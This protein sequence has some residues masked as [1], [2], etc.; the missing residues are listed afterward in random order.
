M[1]FMKTVIFLIGVLTL[2]AC[3]SKDLKNKNLKENLVEKIEKFPVKGSSDILGA[4]DINKLQNIELL[5]KKYYQFEV[6]GKTE[7]LVSSEVV[8][9]KLTLT[10]KDDGVKIDKN[11]QVKLPNNIPLDALRYKEKDYIEM[12]KKVKP[13]MV[14]KIGDKE[15][16]IFPIEEVANRYEEVMKNYPSFLNMDEKSLNRISEDFPGLTDILSKITSAEELLGIYQFVSE[17]YNLQQIYLVNKSLL[18]GDFRETDIYGAVEEKFGLTEAERT[19]IFAFEDLTV[20]P[21]KA[22]A[23]KEAAAVAKEQSEKWAKELGIGT[24]DTKADALR[25]TLW[26]YELCR[27]ITEQSG[28][29]NYLPYDKNDGISFAEEFGTAR[30]SITWENYLVIKNNAQSVNYEWLNPSNR[31]DL[32]NNVTGRKYFDAATSVEGYKIEWKNKNEFIK[33]PVLVMPKLVS[34]S[35]EQVVKDLKDKIEKGEFVNLSDEKSKK[36]F[37]ELGVDK[38]GIPKFRGKIFYLK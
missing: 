14:K 15:V 24:G 11:I 29:L 7:D 34:P 30:E 12:I 37:L 16:A 31:M 3:S 8:K 27:R 18:T 1:K 21:H 35:L 2:V 36:E 6:L 5:N 25:H 26:M 10:T 17:I 4:I 19:V 23:V 32:N 38:E 13:D 22:L 9:I 20:K 33:I 28:I